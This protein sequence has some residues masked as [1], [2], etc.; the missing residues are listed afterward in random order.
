M[1]IYWVSG[2]LWKHLRIIF[3]LPLIGIPYQA[4]PLYAQQVASLRGATVMSV[5]YEPLAQP[6][7]SR[8]LQDAQMVE[9]GRPLDPKEVAATIDRLFATGLYRDI[10]AYA[11]PQNGG[12]A[13][14]FETTAQLFIGHVMA[15]GKIKDPPSRSVILA[16]TQL[17]LGKPF[18]AQAVDTARKRIEEELRRNG[19]FKSAV[20]FTTIEDPHTHQ[21]MIGFTIK[22]GKRARYLTPAI[23]GETKLSDSAI[24]RATGWRIPLIHLWRQVTKAETDKGVDDIGKL[25]AKKDRLTATVNLTGMVYDEQNNRAEPHLTINA[26]PIVSVRALEA[27]VSKRTLKKYVPVFEEGAVDNDLL[28]EGARNLSDYFQSRGYPDVDVLFKREPI[29]DDREVIN[30]YIAAGLRRRLV[31]VTIS[32]NHYFPEAFLR[33]RLFLHKNTLLLR[34]GRYSESFLTKDEETLTSLFQSNGFH[35]VRVS[36]TVAVGYRGKAND[37]AVTFHIS[38]G[39]QWIVSGLEIAGTDRLTIAPIMANLDS[40][41]GQPFA[42]VNVS[43]DRN[44][45]LEYYRSHGFLS[46]SFSYQANLDPET[47][48]AR[49]RYEISEGA[50]EFVRSVLVSGLDVTRSQIVDKELKAIQ[51]GEPISP[52]KIAD[53]SRKLS[54]LGVFA[55]VNTAM[56]DDAGTARYK[57]VLYDFDEANRYTFNVGLG[58]EVGQFGHSTTS[59]S[60]SG[61]AKGV[62]PIVSFDVNRIDFL[63]RAQTL[64]LQTKYSTLEQRESLSYIVPRFLKSPNRVFTLSALYDT[65]QDVQTFSARRAEASAQVSQRL[66]RAST[67]VARFAYRRVSVGNLYIPSLLVPQLLQPV[68]I[69]ILSLSYIQDHRDNPSDAHRGFYNTVDSGLAGGFFASQ[70]SFA[71]LLVRNATYTPIGGKFVFARQTQFGAIVPF[72]VAAGLS[73]FDAVPLPERLF[74]GGGVSMRGFGDN[75]AGPRDVGTPTEVG[76]PASD[77]TGFPIGG[78]GLFFNTFELRFPL[79]GPNI[80]GVVFHDMGNI[81]RNLGDISLAYKQPGSANFNYAVQAPG[82]GIR[83]KTPLGPVRVDL[84]YALNPTNYFGYS[85]SLTIQQLLACGNGCP[86]GPQRLSHF[87]FFFSIGQAF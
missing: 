23:V 15:N 75:Q 71:R 21:V 1:S 38:E 69:G 50:Q 13:V 6:I 66:N 83:Y 35:S 32:G 31:S 34:Y 29:K 43:T 25:Y 46:A 9:I 16:E 56:Q 17:D 52:T 53:V 82:F 84:S 22:A 78:N 77:A 61:G 62:S 87:N 19:L 81:Y 54:D 60:Q 72:S 8:D 57:Y 51:P 20:D 5:Q 79:L 30:Y 28:T 41:Q 36:S 18:D 68:R 74:G 40:V 58:L 65:T 42:E 48:A 45:I 7:D 3:I 4:P 10:K 85:N 49:L 63:G 11:E 59:L 12:V 76:P 55:G 37:V 27:K 24:L 67:L 39:P 14:R 47:H 26:G 64:S 86:S 80:G 73:S 33:G 2:M 44:R 70:R